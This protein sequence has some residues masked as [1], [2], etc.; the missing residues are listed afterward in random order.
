MPIVKTLGGL[1]ATQTT[2][3]LSPDRIRRLA[4]FWDVLCD[5]IHGLGY[6]VVCPRC[7]RLFGEGRDGVRP[8]NS[9]GSPTLVIE[10]GCTR[11]V[12]QATVN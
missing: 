6:Q 2:R 12:F 1:V 4:E 7:T 5:P 9:P 3:S 8:E 10:C 11:H